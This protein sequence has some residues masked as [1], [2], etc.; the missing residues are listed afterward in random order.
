MESSE[1]GILI[2]YHL[3]KIILKSHLIMTL[4]FKKIKEIQMF[5]YKKN[6]KET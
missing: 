6:R 3:R 1:K 5:N 2:Y 4:N